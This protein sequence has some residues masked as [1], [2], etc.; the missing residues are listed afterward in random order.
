ML[1]AS[2][3]YA[4]GI[5]TGYYLWRP[6]LWWLVA[7]IVFSASEVY[8]LRRRPRAAFA[9]VLL[10]LFVTGALMMQVRVP[11]D[12]GSVGM[13][14][15]ADGRDLIVNAHVTKEGS[16]REKS[17]GDTQQRLDLRLSR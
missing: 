2:L 15:L 14:A 3:A 16:P 7:A 9:L 17:P 12:H 11:E 13:L 8:F 10:A 5:V 6:P 4:S 1:W